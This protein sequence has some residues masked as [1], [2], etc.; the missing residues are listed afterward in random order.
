MKLLAGAGRLGEDHAGLE[1]G[2]RRLLE[3]LCVWARERRLLPD[4]LGPAGAM[5]ACRSTTGPAE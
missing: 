5:V 1:A 3:L 2:C 4:V